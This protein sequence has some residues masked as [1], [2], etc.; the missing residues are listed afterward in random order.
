[1]SP[2]AEGIYIYMESV[3][4]ARDIFAIHVVKIYSAPLLKRSE[5]DRKPL[6]SEDA[7]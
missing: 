3:I 2:Y 1:M 6:S 4:Y 5:K 7:L